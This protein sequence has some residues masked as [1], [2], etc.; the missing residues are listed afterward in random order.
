[1]KLPDTKKTA[2]VILGVV[3]G[4][5]TFFVVC[6]LTTELSRSSFLGLGLGAWAGVFVYNYVP[7]HFIARVK[8]LTLH[9]Q[10]QS[11]RLRAIDALAEVK[12]TLSQQYFAGKSWIDKSQDRDKKEISFVCR[13][14]DQDVTDKGPGVVDAEL[15]LTVRVVLVDEKT[16]VSLDYVMSDPRPSVVANDI[17]Q[18]TTSCIDTALL[19]LEGKELCRLQA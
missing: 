7:V 19:N 9:P 11:Y 10:P 16:M 13:Y 6:A 3:A 1:M 17:C 8:P 15:Q 4:I 18:A 5:F 14:Q 2:F 12:N